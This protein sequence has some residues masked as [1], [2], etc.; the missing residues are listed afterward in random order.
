MHRIRLS[1][2]AALLVFTGLSTS[3][4]SKGGNGKPCKAD[5]EC[6]TGL[7]CRPTPGVRTES[8]CVLKAE[9]DTVCKEHASCSGRGACSA[10]DGDCVVVSSENCKPSN[11]CKQEGKCTAK[12]GECVIASNEDCAQSNACKIDGNCVAKDGECIRKE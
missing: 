11:L 8:Y 12:G 6:K 1:L 4:D 10:R 7:A 3:C 9:A 2:L 5:S